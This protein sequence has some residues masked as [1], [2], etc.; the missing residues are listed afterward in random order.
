MVIV[1]DCVAPFTFSDKTAPYAEIVVVW[2]V[3]STGV[4]G[5]GWLRSMPVVP[6]RIDS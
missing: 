5:F 4:I 2:I 3:R 1:L 6:S